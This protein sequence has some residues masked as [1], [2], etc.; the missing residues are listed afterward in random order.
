MERP[1]GGTAGGTGVH[2]DTDHLV[3]YPTWVGLLATTLV[4]AGLLLLGWA[5]LAAGGSSVL[6]WSLIGVAVGTGVWAGRDFPRHVIVGPDGILRRC[7]LRTHRLGYVEVAAIQRAPASRIATARA[8][9][10]HDPQQRRRARSGLVAAGPGRRRWMLT[11]QPESPEEY[12]RL[13]RL[14]IAHGTTDLVAARPAPGA[15]PTSLYRR[16]VPDLA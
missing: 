3:L 10:S 8:L 4:P 5:A 13:A 6:G 7:L 2:G 16:R 15:S 9:R 11:D 14:L 12:D 1:T